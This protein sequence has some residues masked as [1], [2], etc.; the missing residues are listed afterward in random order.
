[1][2]TRP[3]LERREAGRGREVR[4]FALQ[5]KAAGEDGKIEGYGSVFGVRDSYDDVIAAGA[6]AA[7]LAAHKAAGTMPAMLWQHDADRPI[8]IWTDMG[9][10]ERGLRMQGQLALETVLGKE[11]HALLKL[12]A[13]NGLSI[14]FVSKQWAYDRDSDI[15][16]LTEIELWEVSL[17]TFPANTAA[18]VTGVKSSEDIAAPKDAERILRDAG[19]SKADATAFVSRCMRMGEARRDSADSAAAA[20][21]AAQRLLKSLQP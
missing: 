21:Q 11:A 1:M 14:G 17:V 7:T 13:L 10:D 6:F 2:T 4:S 8:G 19:F 16:T 20:L 3:R 5:I 12:G 15:R 9:E 18:R